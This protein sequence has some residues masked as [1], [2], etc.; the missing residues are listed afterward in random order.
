M[1]EEICYV[2]ISKQQDQP[3]RLSCESRAFRTRRYFNAFHDLRY[4]LHVELLKPVIAHDAVYLREFLEL[5]SLFQA[6]NPQTCQKDTHV[7]YESEVWVNAFNVTLQIAKCC[8]SFSDCYHALLTATQHDRAHT[9]Q[10]LVRA[11]ARV[12]KAIDDWGAEPIDKT[13]LPLPQVPATKEYRQ[14]KVTLPYVGDINVVQYD[15][16]SDPVSFHHP[17]HWLLAGILESATWLDSALVAEAGWNEGFFNA[18]KMFAAQ[19]DDLLPRVL[20]FPIRT[21]AF[22][23]QIR[24]G[25]WVRNGYNIRNQV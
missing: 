8:R 10:I 19:D 14:H 1:T 22:S 20:D 17:L 25:V 3:R 7:E 15:I 4:I 12:L 2:P 5:I 13:R 6:M 24:A 11:V 9:A 18:I 16:T 23:S 21:L